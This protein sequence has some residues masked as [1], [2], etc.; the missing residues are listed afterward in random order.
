[1]PAK[2]L[3][4]DWPIARYLEMALECLGLSGTG[5]VHAQQLLA[6]HGLEVSPVGRGRGVHPIVVPLSAAADIRAIPPEWLMTDATCRRCG[7]M[8]RTCGCYTAMMALGGYYTRYALQQRDWRNIPLG[9]Y[10]LGAVQAP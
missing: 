3:D 1:M 9:P 4:A 8:S 2:V 7:G 5:W 6:A 10:P